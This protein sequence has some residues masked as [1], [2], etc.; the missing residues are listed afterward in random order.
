MIAL[1][2]GPM[3]LR[4][5]AQRGF[6]LVELMVAMLIGLFVLGGGLAVFLGGHQSFRTNEGAARLQE[7][8]RMG[9]EVFSR[10]L[11]QAGGNACGTSRVASA[12]NNPGTHWGTDW[13]A[14]PIQGVAASVASPTGAAQATG[15]AAAARVSG[16]PAVILRHASDDGNALT[17]EFSNSSHHLQ[18]TK[19]SDHGLKKDDIVMACSPSHAII[20]QKTS[21][22]T[23]QQIQRGTGNNV[24]PGNCSNSGFDYVA[25]PNCPTTGDASQL[26]GGYLVRVG[27]AFWYVGHNDR[28]GRS[29]YRQGLIGPG[30]NTERVEMVEGVHDMRLSYLVEGQSAYLNADHATFAANAALWQQVVA[31]RV[32]LDMVSQEQV[33]VT[34]TGQQQA[35]QRTV[36]FTVRLRNAGGER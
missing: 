17:I 20:F 14:G 1:R 29:L 6:S 30:T 19:G 8:A 35:L 12:L 2:S 7:N 3:H 26:A 15:T 25:P 28:G 18:V 31:I 22:N 23:N 4:G 13:S 10:D 32:E 21:N 11:R 36:R 33:G 9:F 16:T 5:I 34:A 27:A 24:S